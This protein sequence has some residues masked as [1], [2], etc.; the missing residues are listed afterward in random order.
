MTTVREAYEALGELLDTNGGDEL[1]IASQPSWPMENHITEIRVVEFVED[2]PFE[3][4]EDSPQ[5]LSACAVCGE[6][7]E[8]DDHQMANRVYVVEGSQ[9]DNVYLPGEAQKELGW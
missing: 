7:A 4:A 8:H 1:F 5:D 3:F 6:H 9:T 2:H